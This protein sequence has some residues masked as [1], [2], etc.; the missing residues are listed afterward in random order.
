MS[1]F[2]KGLTLFNTGYEIDVVKIAVIIAIFDMVIQ[3][4]RRRMH[5]SYYFGSLFLSIIFF[6]AWMIFSL[7]YSPSE[8]YKFDKMFSFLP[9]IIFFFVSNFY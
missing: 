7:S 2:L 8:V 9:N 1:G 5:F 3:L 4:I 6:Y